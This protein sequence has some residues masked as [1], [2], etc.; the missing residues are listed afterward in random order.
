MATEYKL[1]YTASEINRKLATVDE[2]KSVLESNYYTSTEV[3]DKII[4]VSDNIGAQIDEVNSNLNTA[5]ETNL[6]KKADLIE[7]KVPVEQ[8]P[9]GIVDLSGYYTKTEIDTETNAI[10]EDVDSK[11]SG[12]ADLVDGKVPVEQLPDDI[13]T[14]IDLENA[15]AAIDTS[16]STA[17]G[18]G[19]LA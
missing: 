9:D 14:K 10:K 6:A 11:L 7:G 5:L 8:I 16:L 1:S 12:K 15:I 18:S 3:D 13:A 17:I 19:V 4:E 2:T